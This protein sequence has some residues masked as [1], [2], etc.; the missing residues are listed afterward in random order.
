M[1]ENFIISCPACEKIFDNHSS[2]NK[3]IQNCIIYD[4][5]IKN[6]IPS[7]TF[8]CL[9]CEMKFISE[10]YLLLHKTKCEKYNIILL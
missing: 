10:E 7:K 8:T 5:W 4:S 1:D 9:K 3:H 2:L 6:Y